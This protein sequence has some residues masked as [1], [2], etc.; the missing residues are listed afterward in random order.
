MWSVRRRPV[1]WGLG[2]MLLVTACGDGQRGGEL[3]ADPATPVRETPRPKQATQ[4]EAVA[5]V[6]L[7]DGAVRVR[8]RDGE[9][10]P[11]QVGL[12]IL[13]DD[14]FITG[15]GAFL[16]AELHNG[17]VVSV[18][19]DLEFHVKDL[20]MLESPRAKEGFEAQ[21]RAILASGERRRVGESAAMSE[22]I[23]GFQ[24]RLESGTNLPSE[25]R[26]ER[27]LP[28][29][30]PKSEAA[31]DAGKDR[32]AI[33]GEDGLPQGAPA[34]APAP[35]D[36]GAFA[37]SPAAAAAGD[38]D[39]DKDGN[40]Y[41]GGLPGKKDN[42]APPP[43]AEKAKPKKTSRPAPPKPEPKSKASGGVSPEEE[44][45]QV[46]LDE[47]PASDFD[48]KSEVEEGDLEKQPA[49]K[50]SFSW[51]IEHDGKDTP[52][53][54]TLVAPFDS[55]GARGELEAAARALV[56]SYPA[57]GQRVHLM[58]RVHEGR[59]TRAVVKGGV[60][61]PASLHKF[62]QQSIPIELSSGDVWVVLHIELH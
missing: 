44:K 3:P 2:V 62:V 26:E 5:Y 17:Y 24:I 53:G 32:L 16:L 52:K 29:P 58:F 50:V 15:E 47:P 35:S 61:T 37:D 41:A 31:E 57:L 60:P 7:V 43:R 48:E 54:A 28:M 51:S 18:D 40:G 49:P 4:G 33:G 34:P 46:A 36:A 59:I 27:E 1:A 10:F 21:V 20:V 30:A 8:D 25:T 19:E 56:E 11:A 14:V 42:R 13:K 55:A 12:P 9:E 39:G 45:P 22:R 38:D 23:A 6:E